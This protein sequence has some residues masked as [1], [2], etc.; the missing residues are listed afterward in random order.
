MARQSFAGIRDSA[1]L[2]LLEFRPGDRLD[3]DRQFII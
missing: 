3:P 2:Q 1:T